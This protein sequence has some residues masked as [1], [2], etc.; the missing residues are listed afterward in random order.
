MKYFFA[1]SFSVNPRLRKLIIVDPNADRIF[2]RLNDNSNYGNNFRERL[3]PL[4]RE[5]ES[6]SFSEIKTI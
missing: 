4:S 6:T 1:K 5:W 3:K 2:S